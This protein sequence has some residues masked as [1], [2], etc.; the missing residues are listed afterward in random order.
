MKPAASFNVSV[1]RGV[2]ISGLLIFLL[3]VLA[4]PDSIWFAMPVTELVTSV[5]V[6]WKIREYTRQLPERAA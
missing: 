1:A 5:Y 2:V 3:P 6:V 4:G